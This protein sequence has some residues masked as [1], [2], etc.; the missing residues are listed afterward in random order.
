MSPSLDAV[1]VRLEPLSSD[2]RRYI[3]S[4]LSADSELMKLWVEK[5]RRFF[6]FHGKH[7]LAASRRRFSA[8]FRDQLE[9]MAQYLIL[10]A[11]D[12]SDA[13]DHSV[14]NS[15]LYYLPYAPNPLRG[16]ILKLEAELK[17]QVLGGS[18]MLGLAPS[19]GWDIPLKPTVSSLQRIEF[20]PKIVIFCPSEKSLFCRV[21]IDQLCKLGIHPSLVIIRDI[22]FTRVSS[23]LYRDGFLRLGKKIF[24][25]HFLQQNENHAPDSIG[26]R[27]VCDRLQLGSKSVLE[28]ASA[29]SIPV[30]RTKDFLTAENALRVLK[31][32]FGI[33][34]GGGMVGIET[35]NQFSHGI[36]NPH[37]GSLPQYRGMDVVQ[38]TILDGAL[39]EV[40]I[41]CHY[42]KEGVDTGPI[43]AK[44]T[45]DATRFTTLGGLRNALGAIQPVLCIASLIEVWCGKRTPINQDLGVGKQYYFTHPRLTKIIDAKFA[46]NANS[47]KYFD[48]L[49]F[50]SLVR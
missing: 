18:R 11:R 12:P 38:A 5:F 31:P 33:F 3:S 41:T 10:T 40:G 45:I 48:D 16:S 20:K 42:M 4:S 32:H 13:I 34:G 23:E 1:P 25:K 6:S 47:S 30:V 43:L 39:N 49:I 22:S 15:L 8:D 26:L 24:R 2:Q 9:W 21:V 28:L 35:I 46:R 50:S 44:K 37:M 14:V 27:E 7:L 36:I 19:L 17:H 29:R